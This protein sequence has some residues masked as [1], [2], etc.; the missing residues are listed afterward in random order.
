VRPY[1]PRGVRPRQ[2]RQT[3]SGEMLTVRSPGKINWCL[4]V[5]RR[6]PDGFHDL[7]SLVSAVSLCDEL[8]FTAH[9]D[10]G[11]M[12]TCDRADI[13]TDE[14]NLVIRAGV[15][16]AEASGYRAGARCRLSKR[17]PAGGGMGGGSSNGAW[18]LLALN[19]LWRLDWPVERLSPLAALLGSDVPFFLRGCS[20]VMTGRGERIAP[21]AL[22]WS[23]WI[24]LLLPDFATSTAEVYRAWEPAEQPPTLMDDIMAGSAARPD[25]AMDWMSASYNMLEEPLLR[26]CPRMRRL[27]DAGSELA[28]RPVR[29]S[30]SGSTLFTAFDT[31]GEAEGF[32]RDAERRLDLKSHVV[33][34]MEETRVVEEPS[35]P[36]AG[37]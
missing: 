5:L 11:I 4:R 27:L 26:V 8:T 23:G 31:R 21:V 15:L 13:P 19:R 16:L 36:M 22:P 33:Q 6:R 18:T 37:Q 7:S 2:G 12:L 25:G 28:G 10:P 1:G 34:P 17:I 14:R 35:L 3:V 9:P 24:V 30:G 29:V 20:A 32:A